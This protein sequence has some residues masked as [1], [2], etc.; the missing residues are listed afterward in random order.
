MNINLDN[1]ISSSIVANSQPVQGPIQAQDTS[2]PN[3][4]GPALTVTT[5]TAVPDEIAA[6]RLSDDEFKRDDWLGALIQNSFT[7]PPPPMP[8]LEP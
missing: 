1:H 6:A 4:S 5:A 7:Y 3:E 2:R 8:N